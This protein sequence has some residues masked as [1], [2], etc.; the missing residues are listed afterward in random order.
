MHHTAKCNVYNNCDI[1]GIKLNI[2]YFNTSI[3]TLIFISLFTPHHSQS[4]PDQH[5]FNEAKQLSQIGVELYTQ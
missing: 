4:I 2:A 5:V 3:S 1:S